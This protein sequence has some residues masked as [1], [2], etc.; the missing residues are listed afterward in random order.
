MAGIGKGTEVGYHSSIPTACGK[1]RQFSDTVSGLP[2][3]I[4]TRD[5]HEHGYVVTLGR[6]VI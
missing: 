1:G 6:D 4:R 5:P 3:Y 2:D